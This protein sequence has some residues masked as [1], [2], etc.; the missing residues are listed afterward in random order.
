M[1]KKNYVWCQHC[2]N[3]FEI[4]TGEAEICPHCETPYEYSEEDQEPL[5]FYAEEDW[6]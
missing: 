5:G 3:E 2:E 1:V 6:N 4:V